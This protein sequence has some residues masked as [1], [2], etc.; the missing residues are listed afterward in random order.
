[1]L[2]GR[3]I[4]M[5]MTL[6]RRLPLLLL[7][8]VVVAPLAGTSAHSAPQ[9]AK[10]RLA[11]FGSCGQLLDYAKGQTKRFVGPYGFGGGGGIAIDTGVP[12]AAPAVP[13][14][15][16]APVVGVDYSGTNV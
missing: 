15:A 3:R 14:R 2:L 10:P 16:A 8:A 13:A 4:T 6:V 5:V 1:M 9:A 12:T 7:A 11:A